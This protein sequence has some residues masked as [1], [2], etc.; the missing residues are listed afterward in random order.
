MF[1]LSPLGSCCRSGLRDAGEA[2]LA[3]ADIANTS[4][5]PDL[6][7]KREFEYPGLVSKSFLTNAC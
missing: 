5:V 1:S 3:T 2:L 4:A 6:Y 7:I